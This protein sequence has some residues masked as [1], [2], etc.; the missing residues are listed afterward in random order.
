MSSRPRCVTGKLRYKDRIAALLALAD[1]SRS[2]S[3]KREETRVY[4]CDKCHGWHL[5]SKQLYG[6]PVL[7]PRAERRRTYERPQLDP[8]PVSEVDPP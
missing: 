3:G 4:H 6:R 5:T 8:S 2:A 1:T 7:E